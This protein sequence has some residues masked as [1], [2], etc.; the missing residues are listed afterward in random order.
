MKYTIDNIHEIVEKENVKFIRLQFTDIFGVIKNVEIPVS[1]LDKALSN[2]IMFDGSSIDGFVRIEESDMYL[3]PNIDTW[4]VYPWTKTNDGGAVGRFICDI[5]MPDGT[6][7]SG[8]P[9]GNL[10][11]ILKEM[12]D[13]GFSEFNLGPEPEFYLFKKDEKGHPIMEP[14]DTGG[15]FDF[16]PVDTGDNCRR[17]IVIELEKMGFE[18][19][20]SH[21]EVGNG[22]HE[23]DF[24]YTDVLTACD[25][26]QTFKLAVKTIAREH[27]LHATFMAKP[28]TGHAGS[29]M[30]CNV[31]LAKDGKNVFF[32]ENTTTQLSAT[33]EQFIAGLMDNVKGFTA[34]TNPTINSYKRLVPGYEA[35]CFIAWSSQNR[36]PL[37]RIPAARGN[38]TRVEL[39][40]VD[41]MANPYLAL[42][43]ILK[44]GL[45]GIK[46]EM[47][48]PAEIKHNIYLM[49]EAERE[50]NGI[51]NLPKNL[52]E[53]ISHL[54][55]NEAIKD[56]LGEH[57]FEHFIM[58]KEIELEA[59]HT[60]V[61]EW[62]R[63]LYLKVY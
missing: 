48:P 50:A 15:Y 38:S 12:D 18:V 28:L 57:I 5:Y 17:D 53:A 45:D 46:N 63:E 14:N 24:K 60:N 8:D 19:E 13:L 41:P 33:A 6:P 11:R 23:I 55:A 16:A 21:H 27:N 4:A 61:H 59:F 49:D 25:Q 1:Q 39:R 58:A 2:E 3:Y 10:K 37:V 31:S 7:F 35:P 43:V 32:D 44:A 42:A 22:Q 56:A 9:R 30:H 34:I 40:S 29:G 47:T 51:A 52:S 54:K 26:I 36:S 62:E 20:A